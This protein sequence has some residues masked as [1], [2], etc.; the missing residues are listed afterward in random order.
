MTIARSTTDDV[1]DGAADV[2]GARSAP[3]IVVTQTI[4]T[5]RFNSPRNAIEIDPKVLTWPVGC[6]RFLGA[7]AVQAELPRRWA[8]IVLAVV[9]TGDRICREYCALLSGCGTHY[10]ERNRAPGRPA[11]KITIASIGIPHT[12]HRILALTRQSSRSNASWNARVSSYSCCSNSA[13]IGRT[14]RSRGT[15]VMESRLTTES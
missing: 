15:V 13:P 4:G 7:H 3:P 6:R 11:T 9:M 1:F 2:L 8:L 5:G 10:G 12:G 14:N